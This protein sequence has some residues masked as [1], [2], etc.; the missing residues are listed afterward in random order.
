MAS[1]RSDYYPRL[2][3]HVVELVLLA[4]LLRGAYDVIVIIVF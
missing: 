1:R 3:R 4:L 2:H